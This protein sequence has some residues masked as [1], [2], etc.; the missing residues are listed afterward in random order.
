[1][2]TEFAGDAPG[3]RRC[4]WT[5]PCCGASGISMRMRACGEQKSIPGNWER[6]LAGDKRRRCAAC[7][8]IFCGKRL[9]FADHQFLIFLTRKASRE[10]ISGTIGPTDARERIA[11]A[12]KHASGERLWRGEVA[13]FA[14][15]ASLRLAG[16]RCCRCRGAGKTGKKKV[17]QRR[18]ERSGWAGVKAGAQR[19]KGKSECE[20][21][22][23]GSAARR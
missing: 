20:R 4:C 9:C 2:Q 22:S 11:I 8:R 6:N 7:C 13:I 1:M 15:G 10:N 5:R 17:T 12:A 16:S 19:G 14:Q 21:F 3:S 23:R 18:G